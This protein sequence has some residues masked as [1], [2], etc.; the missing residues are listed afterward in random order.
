MSGTQHVSLD[1]IAAQLQQL[2]AE[3][4]EMKTTLDLD[5]RNNRAFYDNLAFEMTRSIGSID[6]KLEFAVA[7][8]DDRFDQLEQLITKA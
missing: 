7:H 8:F 5:R 3:L 2:L 6:A 1:F 4:R